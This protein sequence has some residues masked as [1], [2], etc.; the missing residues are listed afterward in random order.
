MHRAEMPAL[1]RRAT[2][3][4]HRADLDGGKQRAQS[5]GILAAGPRFDAAG[6]IHGVRLG[7]ANGLGDIF[8]RQ[9]A[10]QDDSSIAP[11]GARQFPIQR[12][13]RAAVQTARESIEQ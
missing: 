5:R 1:K 4:Y 8:R 2:N 10:R 3:V 9:A 11:R 12:A 6:H 7:D 13:A